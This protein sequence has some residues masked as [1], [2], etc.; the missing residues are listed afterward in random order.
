MTEPRR[1]P[2]TDALIRAA[3]RAHHAAPGGVDSTSFYSFEARRE[4][5]RQLHQTLG[6]G[7]ASVAAVAVISLA[8]LWLTRPEPLRYT[9]AAPSVSAAPGAPAETLSFSDGSAVDSAH[10]SRVEVASTSDRGARVSLVRG[11]LRARV[12]PGPDNDWWFSAGPYTVH[13]TGT[14]FALRWAPDAQRFE[15]LLDHGRVTVS[16][17]MAEGGVELVAGQRLLST[18]GTRHLEV[19]PLL[20][21]AAEP[22]RAEPAPR[23]HTPNPSAPSARR[24]PFPELGKLVASGAFAEALELAKK[25]GIGALLEHGPAVE[26][27]ALAD[28]ARYEGDRALARRALMSLRQRFG[29]RPE[30]RKTAYFLGRISE[31]PEAVRWYTRYLTEEP[32]GP[33]AA[34]ALGAL[35]LLQLELGERHKAERSACAYLSREPGGPY[36]AAARRIL[37]PMDATARGCASR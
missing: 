29:S 10:G 16:G 35:T 13:V 30:G 33:F 8:A 11:E 5:R 12:V 36:A 3:Q 32:T 31:G 6:L 25:R 28:A 19:G 21:P 37:D 9:V 34:P 24:E 23:A 2:I 4:R 1:E 27:E 15:L 14:T 22:A 17:P 18:L 26:L 7:V 20:P